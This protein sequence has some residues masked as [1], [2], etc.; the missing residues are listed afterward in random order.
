MWNY[1]KKEGKLIS[2]RPVNP[3]HAMMSSEISERAVGSVW[4]G[5]SG[6]FGNGLWNLQTSSLSLSSS[7]V[8]KRAQVE[9]V[10]SAAAAENIDEDAVVIVNEVEKSWLGKTYKSMK[11]V[12]FPAKN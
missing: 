1:T 8:P 7:S 9:R 4:S 6:E 12:K 5:A 10:I 11:I 2:F 3:A